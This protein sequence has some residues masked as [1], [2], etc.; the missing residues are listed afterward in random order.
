MNIEAIKNNAV[1]SLAKIVETEY[2]IEN[3]LVPGNRMID[4]LGGMKD[5]FTIMTFDYPDI[6]LKSDDTFFIDFE[7][8]WQSDIGGH[9]AHDNGKVK[10]IF[11]DNYIPTILL[12]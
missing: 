10:A 2:L 7:N 1:K 11:D 5:I 6:Y 4:R 3:D 8:D 9:I 12:D